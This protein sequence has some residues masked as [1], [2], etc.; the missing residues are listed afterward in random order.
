MSTIKSIDLANIEEF[1]QVLF[2]MSP[3]E[4]S[5]VIHVVESMK[6]ELEKRLMIRNEIEN[7]VKTSGF[8]LK[9]LKLSRSSVKF[10]I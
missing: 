9:S 7:M 2:Q 6:P 1:K 8:S 3:Q 10:K 5:K 4:I